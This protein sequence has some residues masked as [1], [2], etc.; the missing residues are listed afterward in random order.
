MVTCATWMAAGSERPLAVA[1]ALG[2][3]R[4]LRGTTGKGGSMRYV[5]PCWMC[6]LNGY[7]T[8]PQGFRFYCKDCEVYWNER[9]CEVVW[10]DPRTV[11]L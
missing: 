3:V 1:P 11:G 5:S 4:V 9:H 8:R 7:Q 10:E 6:G 2:T